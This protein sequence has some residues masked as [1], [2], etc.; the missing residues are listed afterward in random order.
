MPK[1]SRP[2]PPQVSPISHAGV[3]YEQVRNAR[4]LG[5][6]QVTGY[7]AAV[8]EATGKQLW[9]LKVYDNR[10]SPE[11]EADVQLSYFKSMELQPGSDEIAVTN[12]AG[13]RFIVQLR[14]R[15]V[16]PAD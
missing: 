3:R 13:R 5:G 8:D 9:I 10:P 11:L 6:D 14:E 12:E 4:A 1:L 7:M 2:P 16:R 15:T